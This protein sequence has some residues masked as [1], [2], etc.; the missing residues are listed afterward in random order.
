MA[1]DPPGRATGLT[2]GLPANLGGIS[3]IALLMSTATGVEVAGMGLQPQTLR[4]QRQGAA[5][6]EGIVEGR[7]PVR[8]K[9]L[10]GARMPGIV[11]AGAAPA[12][13]NLRPRLF[14][15]LL[16][17]RVL[18]ADQLL[19]EAEQPLALLLLVRLGRELLGAGR[20]IV[21]HLPKD[22]RPRRGQGPARPPEMQG[23]RVPVPDRLFPSRRGVDGVEGQGDLDELFAVD[24]SSPCSGQ[25]GRKVS[26]TSTFMARILH[27]RRLFHALVQFVG[28]N[29]QQLRSLG[30]GDRAFGQSTEAQALETSGLLPLHGEGLPVGRRAPA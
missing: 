30:F 12:L 3:I 29:F 27:V 8:V 6:R 14:Q 23:A 25:S 10:G 21:H 17:G 7:Q 15:Q 19:D 11:R 20:G 13:A 9:Q 24:V 22:H 2:G 28:R 5:A 16:V 18:P 1:D 26:E 4:F